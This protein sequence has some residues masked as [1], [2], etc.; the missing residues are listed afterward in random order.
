VLKQPR[1]YYGTQVLDMHD[2]GTISLPP[3]MFTLEDVV[4]PLK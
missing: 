2:C 4:S 1:Y 3:L